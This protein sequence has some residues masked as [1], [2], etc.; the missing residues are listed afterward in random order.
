MIRLAIAATVLLG[1][2]WV[3]GMSP[4]QKESRGAQQVLKHIVLYKFK[5][6]LTTAQ[7][8]EVITAF[9]ALPS[10]VP[11]IIGFE[12]GTNVSKEGKSDGLTHS[13]VVTF[14][15]VADLD[16]YLAHP[17]HQ[18]YVKIVKDRREK[19]VVFDYWVK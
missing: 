3:V 14:A 15:S 13:F 6:T 10:K 16:T 2:G 5:D 7:V 11:G 18:D 8:D 4:G 9:K 19:V 12:A 17:A 1:A